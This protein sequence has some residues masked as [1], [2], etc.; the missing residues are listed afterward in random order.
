V[1]L[2]IQQFQQVLPL[3]RMEVFLQFLQ[4]D[5]HYVEMM[6]AAEFRIASHIQPKIMEKLQVFGA[7]SRSVRTKN[8]AT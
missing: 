8:T 6:Q 3:F 4:R 2:L 7:E 5:G 1:D